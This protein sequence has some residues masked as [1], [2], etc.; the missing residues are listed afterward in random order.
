VAATTSL[1]EV[2]DSVPQE[3]VPAVDE[4]TT[5]LEVVTAPETSPQD[6]QGVIE[7][8][9]Q[10]TTAL[11]AIAEGNLP[12]ERQ[13]RL[14]ALVRQMSSTLTTGLDPEVPPEQRASLILVTKRLVPALLL[15]ADP[16]TPQELGEQ[17]EWITRQTGDSLSRGAQSPRVTRYARQVATLV[18][19][20]ASPEV[21]QGL[22]DELVATAHDQ[23]RSLREFSDPHTSPQ[24]RARAE[25]DMR[26]RGARVNEQQEE[27]ASEQE[28]SGAPLAE[29]AAICTSAIFESVPE[30]TLADGLESLVPDDWDAQGVK[31]F[32]KAEEKDDAL[33]DVLAQ[34]GNDERV[35]G[36]FEIASLI[37]QLAEIV[38]R[39]ELFGTLGTPASQCEQAAADLDQEQGVDSG[40]WLAGAD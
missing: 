21:S 7:S 19:S 25:K 37:P 18:D 9:Q 26:E 5:N 39:D 35:H 13:D 27:A 6:R 28:Q 34:L 14:S 29:E 40:T 1:N 10:L 23:S 8:A 4:L 22:R 38:P 3:L 2:K 17:L 31:D 11:E 24:D 20:A 36:P 15:V 12:D 30:Q 16:G 33:L 32:W